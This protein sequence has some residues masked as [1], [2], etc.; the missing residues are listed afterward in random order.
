MTDDTETLKTLDTAVRAHT[1]HLVEPGEV[2]TNWIVL[3]A[4]RTTNG[5]EVRAI[6]SDDDLPTYVVRGMLDEAR[7]RIDRAQARFEQG[8]D[9]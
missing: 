6:V 8:D 9:A 7:A 1:E 2:I 4:T 3:A 5:G